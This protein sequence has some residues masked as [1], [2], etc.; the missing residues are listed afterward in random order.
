MK[1][2]CEYNSE[3]IINALRVFEEIVVIIRVSTKQ[4][5]EDSGILYHLQDLIPRRFSNHVSRPSIPQTPSILPQPDTTIPTTIGIIV[6]EGKWSDWVYADNQTQSFRPWESTKQ[7]ME[8]CII[9]INNVTHESWGGKACIDFVK[10]IIKDSP[11][12]K[13]VRIHLHYK[14][15]LIEDEYMD[16]NDVEADF[17]AGQKS[18]VHAIAMILW[19]GKFAVVKEV[20]HDTEICGTRQDISLLQIAVSETLQGWMGRLGVGKE[21]MVMCV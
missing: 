6:T 17:K 19:S 20:G 8:N 10:E 11:Q 16:E 18:N 2:R 1:E 5:S 7:T 3:L 21:D 9:T 4:A 12:V 14:K 13:S 15:G